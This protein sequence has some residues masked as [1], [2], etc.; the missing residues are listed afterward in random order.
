M[1]TSLRTLSLAVAAAVT[2]VGATASLPNTAQAAWH[3]HG[4][5]GG[6]HGGWRGGGWGWGWGPGFAFGF[7]GPYAYA[8]DCYLRPRW[9]VNRWGHTVR[10]WV[11][12]CY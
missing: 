8:G 5:H 6:W 3:G 4:W 7:G 12:V 2:I 9:V 1:R 10:R 11:R